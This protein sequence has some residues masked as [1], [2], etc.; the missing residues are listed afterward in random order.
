MTLGG[1]SILVMLTRLMRRVDP[2]QEIDTASD[3]SSAVRQAPVLIACQG[4][5]FLFYIATS[6][7]LTILV[8]PAEFG[9]LLLMGVPVALV[10]LLG[11]LGL[12]DGVVRSREMNAPLASLFFWINV[13]VALI[14]GAVLVILV[15]LFEWWFGG[16]EL[17]DLALCIA[18]CMV[19]G[20]LAAQYRA[21]LRRQL[22][23]ASLGIAE[24]VM[25]AA[26]SLVS[27]QAALLGMGAASIPIGRA[28]GL[29]VE[30][31][32]LVH[33]SGWIPGRISRLGL[34]VPVI[35]FGWKLALSGVFHFGVGAV[36][37]LA[38]GRF[39]PSESLGLVERAQ[40]LSRDV[41]S[42]FGSVVRK[43]AFPVIARRVVSTGGHD[44]SA[45]AKL[46]GLGL[47]AWVPPCF[48]LASLMPSLVELALGEKWSG[49]GP[50]LGW[51]WLGFSFW[52]P[53]QFAV[54]MLLAHGHS[55]LLLKFNGCTFILYLA[56]VIP[57]VWF[58]LLE[59]VAVLSV[60]RLAG[61]IVQLALF[62][63]KC[64]AGWK[65]WALRSVWLSLVGSGLAA[66]VLA[67]GLLVG[68]SPSVVL[69]VVFILGWL[70]LLGLR[71]GEL[72][73]LIRS[74]AN[75]YSW[76]AA[77]SSRSAL[78]ASNE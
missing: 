32:V 24:S 7:I 10:N 43:L 13:S 4:A 36:S 28:A 61:D 42:R 75:V 11:D 2:F 60:L 63:R 58:G 71:S 54:A 76:P 1:H 34:A 20:G 39:Y 41:L 40:S 69:A 12:G 8:S 50:Y 57:G 26:T 66:F 70:L 35:S 37:V 53:N 64:R 14:A 45:G 16:V 19:V 74:V 30:L 25:T 3:I 21:L 56:A 31:A 59:Y 33:L 52:L 22:R 65:A 72:R 55:G 49:L 23:V 27:V 46:V 6:Y 67:V 48:V 62:G 73:S 15:P 5:R 38:L 77:G 17:L 68:A 18:G 29:V 78:R 47:L 44:A 9:R 51:A